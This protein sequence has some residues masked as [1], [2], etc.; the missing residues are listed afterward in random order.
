MR[1][2][3]LTCTEPLTQEISEM[4]VSGYVAGEDGK[5][6]LRGVVVDTTGPLL[7]N[8]FAG[9]FL[10][11]MAKFLS[12]PQQQVSYV[13]SSTPPLIQANPLTAEQLLKGSFGSGASSTLEKYADFYIKRAE[14]LQPVLQVSAGREV[15]IVFTESAQ[16]AETL[17][18]K[19]VARDN[20][21]HRLTQV[22]ERQVSETRVSSKEVSRT[23]VPQA[24][25]SLTPTSWRPPHSHYQGPLITQ[26]GDEDQ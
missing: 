13:P 21:K 9:G 1:L 11:G 26:E 2:E 4:T 6:G 20:D 17:F 10:S 12:A 8:S 5:A 15:D 7:R 24:P 16:I 18:R 14:Q 19:K 3:K 22:S 25:V 23:R